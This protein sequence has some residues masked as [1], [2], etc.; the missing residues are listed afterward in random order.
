ML[1]LLAKE[2]KEECAKSFN[3]NPETSTLVCQWLDYATL[4]V[5]HATKDKQVHQVLL[6]V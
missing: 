2:S 3:Q 4:F 6:K 1:Q 5:D